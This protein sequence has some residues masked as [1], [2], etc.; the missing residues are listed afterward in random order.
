MSFLGLAPSSS[1][2]LVDAATTE[3]LTYAELARQGRT[4]GATLGVDKQ[5]VFLVAR[6][7]AFST[8]AYWG[9]LDAG[10]AVALL[11]GH[12][13]L[14]TVATLVDAYRPTWV[15][16]PIGLAGRLAALGTELEATTELLGGELIRTTVASRR[17]IHADL[18][19]MLT[20]S[21]TTGSRKLVRLSVGNVEAN[22][23]S[24]AESLAL[25]PADRALAMLPFH[26]SFGLSVVNSHLLAGATLVLTNDGVLQRGLWETFDNEACTSLAGVPYTYQMLERVGF[27]QMELPALRVLQQAGGALDRRLTS[28]YRDHMAQRGGRFFV[29]YGQTE[30]TARI[31][32]VP[33]GRLVDKLGSAGVPVPGGR[34]RIVQ[35]SDAEAAPARSQAA[36]EVVY[37]G[38]NVMLGYASAADDLA[39][40]DELRGVLRTGDIGYLDD[41]GFLFLVGRS[42]RIAKVFGHR[43]NLDEVE[44]MVRES[45]PAAVIGGPD[46]IWAFC[47]FGTPA[48]IEDVRQAVAAR[49]RVHRAGLRF[50]H[51]DAIPTTDS[52]KTDYRRVQEWVE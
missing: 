44:A 27:R 15:A 7:D 5:V 32:I 41:E 50:R 38:P 42:R 47:A 45:G 29:M 35:D 43:L 31:A 39:R 3:R 48:E 9:A 19:L 20:T 37:E 24:I 4:I 10:H 30:A 17:D 28:L 34:L 52:G 40:G 22:A 33:P 2:A 13:A 26:Y 12:A 6:N 51:V 36:G 16:G 46:A 21:G 1:I 25:T 8:T 18:G 14:E 49:L 11:D 23:A